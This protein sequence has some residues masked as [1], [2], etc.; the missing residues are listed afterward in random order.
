MPTVYINGRFL[1]QRLTGVQRYAHETLRAL[2]TLVTE[3]GA[4][5]PSF[6][7]LAPEGAA[8]PTLQTIRVA[9]AGRLRG[10]AWEQLD[11]PRIVG[12]SLLLSFGPT[13]PLA[14][15]FQIVTIH[16]AAVHVVPEAYS[17]AFRAWYRLLLPVLARRAPRIMTVSKF[18]ADEVVRY[19]GADS[20]RTHVSGE[21]YEHVLARPADERILAEHGLRRGRYVLAVSS[22]TPHKNFGLVARALGLL[23]DR[24]FEV[25]VAGTINPAVFSDTD[26]YALQTLKLLGY[27]SDQALRA[28]YENAAAFVYPSLYEGFGIPP[29]EAM[30]LGCPV[31]ASRA[32][33]IP[34]TCGDAA[35]YFSPDDP[36]ELAALLTRVTSDPSLRARLVAAGHARLSA[37]GWRGSAR[38]HLSVLHDLLGLAPLPPDR[39]A[40]CVPAAEMS[41]T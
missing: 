31:L 25:A 5:T 12:N 24:T 33:A 13:G 19:F 36:G 2:D 15:R 38:A 20:S 32:A 29:L 11:L 10:N 14:K 37:H 22:L 34:E 27:V 3:L 23:P 7:V 39:D 9:H 26:P 40:A 30:A 21:G 28:L 35:L 17:P 8:L 1:T 16:D 41:S 18:A 4:G 6:T